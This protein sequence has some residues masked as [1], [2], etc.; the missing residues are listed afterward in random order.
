LEEI[1]LYIRHDII[2][3]GPEDSTGEHR[4]GAY[5]ARVQIGVEKDGSPMYKYFKTRDE[6]ENYLKHKAAGSRKKSDS[7]LKEKL[8]E[9]H[10]KSSK[11]TKQSVG[12]KNLFV[13]DK[14]D[15]KKVEKSLPLY[16]R[17]K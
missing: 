16:I 6:Y 1:M 14:K 8:S 5:A 12:E 2:K 15:D 11:H 3:G 10:E 4:G 17:S 7:K 9:E 13:K